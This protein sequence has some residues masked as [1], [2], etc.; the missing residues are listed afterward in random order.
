MSTSVRFEG[1]EVRAVESGVRAVEK[2]HAALRTRRVCEYGRS[3]VLELSGR[4]LAT[5]EAVQVADDDEARFLEWMEGRW[6][7]WNLEK[8][9]GLMMVK[10]AGWHWMEV[11]GGIVAD[12]SSDWRRMVD[13][14]GGKRLAGGMGTE[15]V[16]CQR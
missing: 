14:S 10:V 11:G 15:G 4:A 13:A 2:A 5:I 3:V 1:L 6:A 16:G 8:G 9:K 7:R 12:A